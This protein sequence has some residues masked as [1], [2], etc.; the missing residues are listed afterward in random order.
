MVNCCQNFDIFTSLR[1]SVYVCVKK[2]GQLSKM[3]LD[4]S[5]WPT[6]FKSNKK[7]IIKFVIMFYVS[8]FKIFEKNI[9]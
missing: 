2:F 1:E 8:I 9:L 6:F 5:K 4:V 7:L 3:T